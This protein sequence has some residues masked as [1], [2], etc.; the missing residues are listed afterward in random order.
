MGRLY[1]A[2]MNEIDASFGTLLVL[3]AA[4]RITYQANDL[5]FSSCIIMK[6]LPADALP[7]HSPGE[8]QI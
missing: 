6:E 4:L 3:E 7:A 2:K 5:V 1:R 8:R